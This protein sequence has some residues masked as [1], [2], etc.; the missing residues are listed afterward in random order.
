[1][2]ARKLLLGV[3]ALGAVIALGT[4]LSKPAFEPSGKA[5]D[6]KV[7]DLVNKKS[8]TSAELKGKPVVLEFWATWC[9][10]CRQAAPHMAEVRAKY[11]PKGL[12]VIQVSDEPEADVQNWLQNQP[13]GTPAFIDP[14]HKVYKDYH[15]DPIPQVVVI[16]KEGQIIYIGQPMDESFEPA[17]EQAL[18]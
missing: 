8:V 10:I 7:V 1:M 14:D 9:S 16:N 11:E 2:I 6:F 3:V 15:I 17:I 18:S 13:K 12:Q 5:P 4:K